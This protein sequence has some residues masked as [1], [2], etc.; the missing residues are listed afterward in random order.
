M[1]VSRTL[2]SVFLTSRE[3]ELPCV[4]TE[5]HVETKYSPRTLRHKEYQWISSFMQQEKPVSRIRCCMA[6]PTI[7]AS[8]STQIFININ[9]LCTIIFKWL[10]ITHPKNALSSRLFCIPAFFRKH[11]SIIYNQG[12]NRKRAVKQASTR[13]QKQS[14]L[15]VTWWKK[16]K[17]ETIGR[18][19]CSS[20]TETEINAGA[21]TNISKMLEIG[22]RRF[23]WSGKHCTVLQI[24]PWHEA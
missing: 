11:F 13:W 10:D 16:L 9:D 12:V 4:W 2:G 20:G 14:P 6:L 1:I 18:S 3:M 23:S 5:A 8:N 22:I 7:T 24:E 17:T 15:K 21:K 19:G